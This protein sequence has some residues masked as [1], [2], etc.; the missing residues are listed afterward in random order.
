MD[1]TILITSVPCS[2]QGNK[3][4]MCG[5]FI[6][7]LLS[8]FLTRGL[9]FWLGT[10]ENG[11]FCSHFYMSGV[12]KDFLRQALGLGHFHPFFSDYTSTGGVRCP[13][14]HVLMP[15]WPMAQ[16]ADGDLSGNRAQYDTSQ[17]LLQSRDHKTTHKY[18]PL[19]SRSVSSAQLPLSWYPLS[20][21]WRTKELLDESERG[22]WK[23]WLKTQHSEN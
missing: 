7:V 21:K 10:N 19:D 9:L 3:K 11:I 22:E 18:I 2:S 4:I 16:W 6:I 8:I 20:N 14:G 1:T 17:G 15:V 23:S 5:M 12:G 13:K